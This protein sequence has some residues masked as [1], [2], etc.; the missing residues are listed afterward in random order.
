MHLCN[1]VRL[2]RTETETRVT[3]CGTKPSRHVEDLKVVHAL[4]QIMSS[5]A[6]AYQ[7]SSSC[8]GDGGGVGGCTNSEWNSM[9]NDGLDFDLLAEYLLEDINDGGF[10]FR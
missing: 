3:S 7:N 6:L 8:V 5:T 10:D 1:L 9:N 2:R 4:Q